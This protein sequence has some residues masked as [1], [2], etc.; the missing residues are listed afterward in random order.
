[1]TAAQSLPSAPGKPQAYTAHWWSIHAW[2]IGVIASYFMYEQF[3]LIQNIHT[4]VFKISPWIVGVILALPRLVDGVLDPILGHWSDNMRSR[5]GR[6][7]PF[8]FFS[9][10]AGSVLA[11]SIFWM[12]PEWPEWVKAVFLA[13]AAVSLFTACGTYD[14]AHIALGYELSEGYA[15]RSRIQAIKA[16]YHSMVAMVGGYVIWMAGSLPVMGDFVFGGLQSAIGFLWGLLGSTP[17]SGWNW[18]LSWRESVRSEVTGFRV[19][20]GVISFLIFLTVFFPMI[21]TRERY[22][23]VNR[24]HVDIWKALKATLKCRPFLVILVINFT[25][26][27][28]KLSRDLFFYIGTYYVCFG[29]KAAYSKVMS[30]HGA[31]IAFLMALIIWP[32]TKPITRWIGK[33]A[34]FIGG[35][36]LA[37]IS[38]AGLPFVIR[39]GHVWDWFIYNIAF[40]PA[41]HILGAAS[42]GI[43]PDICDLDELACGERREGLFTAVQSFVNKMEISVMSILTGIF[44][45]LTGFNADYGPHQPQW[46]LDRMRW[47]AFTPLI[48]IA[49]IAFVMSW[50]MPLTEQMMTKVRAELD[51]RHAALGVIADAAKAAAAAGK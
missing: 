7:R 44:L 1:M 30:G 43:M 12:S 48:V 19:I 45:T 33:R 14:M 32:L 47:M 41:N 40:S 37:V 13:G 18:W 26:T 22:V 28:G 8:L 11:S 27:T 15:D 38:A 20:S 2:G 17:P 36:G 3:Y 21:W 34:A 5:W 42:N 31:V 35:A 24:T 50:F 49:A 25:R 16:V 23:K 51:E 29:D 10:I 6:R 46:V 9:A 39:P 4:T